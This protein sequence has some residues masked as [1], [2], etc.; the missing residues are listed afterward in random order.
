MKRLRSISGLLVGVCFLLVPRSAQTITQD[1]F[2]ETIIRVH[3]LFEKERLT[4]RIV[5]E[6][7]NSFLG[8]QDWNLVSNA[9]YSHEEPA[10]AIA[11]PEQTDAFSVDG[12]LEKVFWKT[13]GRLSASFSSFHAA[14][15]IDPIFGVP[16]TWF[17]N[18]FSVSYVHPLLKN[19]NGFLDRLQY[20]L[21]KYDVDFSEVQSFE[22]REE[23]LA[24]VALKFLDWVF[25]TEQRRIIGERLKLSREELE[26]TGK[27]RK[28]NLVEQADVIRA[29][30]AVRIWK[31]NQMLV[32][33]R[34][35]ATRAEL[36]VLS[37]SSSLY[38]ASPE[39]RL[40]DMVDLI[41]LDAAVRQLKEHSR[42]VRALE[43]RLEQL[44]YSRRG[45][46]ETR[47]PDLSLV[48]QFNVKNADQSY[49]GSFKMDKPDALVGLQLS[50]PLG[51]RT[52]NHS[53]TMTDLQIDQLEKE[54]DDLKLSL[55]ASL[56][57][58]YIQLKELE[59]VLE[60]NREQIESAQERTKEELKLYN[61][62]RGELTFVIQSRDNEQN[63][64]LTYASNATMY[65]KL[66]IQYRAL[67]DELYS[68]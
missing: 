58:V 20:D 12:G 29:E 40:Y 15:E 13:G 1:E 7:R 31:Q 67:M 28:A 45:F 35:K 26:R 66:L 3:P 53:I 2:L 61:R 39:F 30:D 41:P 47:K 11:G 49:G 59:K 48:T 36:A 23:F 44:D 60:L 4:A 22:N 18:Q 38:N 55:E 63:A 65:Q 17:Q 57:E 27:K 37:R 9:N 43:I 19:K 33:S 24:R 50:V 46:E 34:W 25:L 14:I 16:D 5:E 54:L 52:A 56:T 42:L 62:G 10:I 32:D 6:E 21:K 68:E 64:E 51:N 8:A